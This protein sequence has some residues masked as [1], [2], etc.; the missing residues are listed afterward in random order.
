M[1]DFIYKSRLEPDQIN[2]MH[3]IQWFCN[4]LLGVIEF[5]QIIQEFDWDID[6]SIAG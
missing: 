6:S 4:S 2:S 5:T 1:S 3:V